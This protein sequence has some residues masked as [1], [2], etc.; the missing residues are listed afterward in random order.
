MGSKSRFV[1]FEVTTGLV[2]MVL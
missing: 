2:V 1:Y